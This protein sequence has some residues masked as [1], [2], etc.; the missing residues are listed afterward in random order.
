MKKWIA[1][2]CAVCLLAGFCACGKTEDASAD[3]S[4]SGDFRVAV[5]TAPDSLNPFAA[6]SELSDELFRLVYDPLWRIGEDGQPENCLVE[7][8]DTSSDNLTWTLRLR[9][10]VTFSDGVALTSADV[11]FSWE[12]F[13]QHSADSSRVFD[14]IS[15]IKCPDDWTVVITTSYVKGDML[16]GE[17]PILPQHIW[18]EYSSSP[19]SMDN[20]AM[21]GSGPFV[22]QAPELSA[23]QEQQEWS[24]SARADYF[25]GRARL[26][27]L[28]FC[29][30]STAI[31]A[32]DAL[33]DGVVDACM[34]LTDA[35]LFVLS[36]GY[37]IEC[38]SVQG[39]GRGHCELVMNMQS[40]ALA[41]SVVREA[42]LYAIDREE[43]FRMGFG[44]LGVYGDGFVEPNS[45][46]YLDEPLRYGYDTAK[47]TALLAGSLYQDYDGDGV[48][49]SRD[50]TMEL[51]FT[52]YSTD[53]VWA[54]AAATILTRDLEP[55]GIEIKWTSLSES[56]L[57][58]K[59]KS[60][61]QW[62]LCLVRR[63]GSL[64]PQDEALLY[65]DGK[66][67]SGWQN[68]SYD[69]LYD[70]LV[71]CIDPAEKAEICKN[72]QSTLLD[73]YPGA[74]LGYGSQVQAIRADRWTGYSGATSS[75]GGLFG[76]GCIAVYMDLAPAGEM[77]T[78][79]ETT[80][81]SG[82]T[83]SSTLPNGTQTDAQE[84][85]PMATA[86]PLEETA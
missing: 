85:A 17:I 52:L 66:S 69:A 75:L 33:S 72:L 48:L 28:T 42:L 73:S 82:E 24:L 34:E 7:S 56:D 10:D 3:E 58:Q 6:D 25:A 43:I 11:K 54:T 35:Q 1:I 18:S 76:T 21:V 5:C 79:T 9:Q 50:N 65:A 22:Y 57:R 32:S 74:V 15:S 46:Y 60:G 20:S 39:P 37:G 59:C 40:G 77:E 62:D 19:A 36:G 53:D 41:D 14:G 63:E 12:L 44:S 47:S 78:T 55:L 26:N 27:S 8:Y 71:T 51:S 2:V 30:Y 49:E 29:L 13:R 4:A 81:M 67:E 83:D 86:V 61:G 70:R 68:D 64:D 45:P 16:Y 84:P 31:D 38:F 80:T 23:G